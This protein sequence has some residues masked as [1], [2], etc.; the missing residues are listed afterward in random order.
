VASITS[1][2]Q[3]QITNEA[4]SNGNR[5]KLQVEEKIRHDADLAG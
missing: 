3:E 4:E 1:K 2:F 5:A